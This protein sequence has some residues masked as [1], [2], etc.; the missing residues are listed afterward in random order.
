[1]FCGFFMLDFCSLRMRKNPQKS[2]SST[3]SNLQNILKLQKQDAKESGPKSKKKLL[4]LRI[5][6]FCRF[7]ALPE[8]WNI[9]AAASKKSLNQLRVYK[10]SACFEFWIWRG[11]LPFLERCSQ[12]PNKNTFLTRIFTS[13]TGSVYLSGCL[14]FVVI[15]M[16][17]NSRQIF[18]RQI[19]IFKAHFENSLRVCCR[20]QK[21]SF[22]EWFQRL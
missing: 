9:K 21:T 1:M 20:R 13:I 6:M 12:N 11:F 18:L 19:T 3:A 16:C 10:N 22:S 8:K 7:D 2:K 15:F 5:L 17:H 4:L 14:F